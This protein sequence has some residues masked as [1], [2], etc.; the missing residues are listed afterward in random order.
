MKTNIKIYKISY[1]GNF[2]NT[3]IL[4]YGE[5]SKNILIKELNDKY[6]KTKIKV[7]FKI[8]EVTEQ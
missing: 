8:E 3:E 6:N 2:G 4:V 1:G 5:I 7:T